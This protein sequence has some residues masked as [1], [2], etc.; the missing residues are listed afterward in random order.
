MLS[1]P[2]SSDDGSYKHHR[3]DNLHRQ[4]T[5]TLSFLGRQHGLGR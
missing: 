1:G 2:V 5:H 4:L 3:K